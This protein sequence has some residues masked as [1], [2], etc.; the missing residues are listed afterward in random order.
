MPQA[1]LTDL[2]EQACAVAGG[3]D[4][5]AVL[6]EELAAL[7]GRL[8]HLRAQLDRF[9]APLTA[10]L[11]G[12]TGV[13]KST[14]L[15]ALAGACIAETGQ[16][17]PTT[18]EPTVYHPRSISEEAVRLEF[19]A[20]RYVESGELDGLILIDT[21]DTDS[22][23]EDHVQRVKELLHQTDIILF[24]GTQQKYITDANIDLLRHV[25]AERKIVCVQTRA[26]QDADIRADW[27]NRLEQEGCCGLRAFRVSALDA[28]DR[29]RKGAP[30]EVAFDFRALADFLREKLPQERATIKAENFI[31]ALRKT[32][33]TASMRL[34]QTR[35]D[36]EGLD[37][38]LAEA[39]RNAGAVVFDQVQAQLSNDAYVWVNALGDAV[40]NHAIGVTGFLFRFLHWVR[41]LP[42]LA[43][44][45]NL[46]RDL[47]AAPDLD[48]SAEPLPRERRRADSLLESMAEDLV[49]VAAE[50]NARL[51]RAG[52]LVAPFEEFRRDFIEELHARLG[53]QFTP[54][55]H[56]VIRRGRR[57]AHWVLPML[58]IVWAGP[59]VFTLAL[60]VFQYYENLLLHARV[61]L[62]ESDFLTRSLLMIAVVVVLELA[63][64]TWGV[65]WAGHRLHN[66]Y[67]RDLARTFKREGIGFAQQRAAIQRSL[68]R[69]RALDALRMRTRAH[70]TPLP[71]RN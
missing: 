51:A 62:P 21:P 56:R 2:Y 29:V 57:I 64:F 31:G 15:N 30:A 11:F 59:F 66:D 58:E 4:P 53:A 44:R 14:L 54:V 67:R 55:R 26:D 39:Q 17:R 5:C 23:C 37:A 22:L 9:S 36:L 28:F 1:Q 34:D 70:G 49:S 71:A 16:R 3:E 18:H 24:C 48:P 7:R 32:L 69:I 68:E 35:E 52:Y 6:S 8:T 43:A 27:L 41:T 40:G 13:G 42:A 38:W 63:A 33:Y 12:G 10:V 50:A 46:L 47:L 19:G 45:K 20:A 25:K 65:R 60:P 61:V